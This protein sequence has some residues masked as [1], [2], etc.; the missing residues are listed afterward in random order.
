MSFNNVHN[1][2]LNLLLKYCGY[3]IYYHRNEIYLYIGLSLI[4]FRLNYY[5]SKWIPLYI[6][7]TIHKMRF[8]IEI[9]HQLSIQ[10]HLI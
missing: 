4:G 8:M 10:S 1:N 3:K 7:F 5:Y 6:L 9:S 2:S